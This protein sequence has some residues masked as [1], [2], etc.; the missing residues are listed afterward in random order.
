MKS[1]ATDGSK[2]SAERVRDEV[3]A[4]YAVSGRHPNLP[5]RRLRRTSRKPA[6]RWAGRLCKRR[7]I[8]TE[9]YTGGDLVTAIA[10]GASSRCSRATAG[11][12]R[13]A[14]P[15]RRRVPARGGCRAPRHQARE[16]DVA[17]PVA[18]GRR[19]QR[20]A[21]GLRRRGV[22]ADGRARELVGFVGT[23]FFGAPEC[24]RTVPGTARR[25]TCGPSG[26]RCSPSSPPPPR[27]SSAASGARARSIPSVLRRPRR[28]HS[29]M[30]L[31]ESLL[32]IEPEARPSAA[33][34]SAARPGSSGTRPCSERGAQRARRG[35]RRRPSRCPKTRTAV[36]GGAAS[37][38]WTASGRSGL[39]A[40]RRRGG[41]GGRLRRRGRRHHQRG[42]RRLLRAA[43]F[44]L[45]VCL[46]SAAIDALVAQ[47]RRGRLE[48]LRA[49]KAF[50]AAGRFG[51]RRRQ[52]A[53]AHR[54]ARR[55]RTTTRCPRW[56]S[57]A[58]SG[59]RAP[60]EAAMQL[61]AHLRAQTT[62]AAVAELRARRQARSS[63]TDGPAPASSPE[64]RAGFRTAD[65]RDAAAAEAEAEEM[66]SAEKAD[67]ASVES[68]LGV[69]F[70]RVTTLA[71]LHARRRARVR[72]RGGGQE[73]PSR[74]GR[75]TRNYQNLR[76]R[77][78][79]RL[80]VPACARR[81]VA[82]QAPERGG[83]RC[84]A[85]CSWPCS[86]GR[87]AAPA[88]RPT[89]GATAG[90]GRSCA[91]DA[92]DFPEGKRRGGEESDGRRTAEDSVRGVSSRDIELAPVVPPM[93]RLQSA[94]GG[95]AER[96]HRALAELVAGGDGWRRW[97]RR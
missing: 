29:T 96:E 92:A 69:E 77:A 63:A 72:S 45:S 89:G 94:G 56:C 50:D 83:P 18:E 33:A 53:A 93:A 47:L 19:A 14:A 79:R 22:C 64:W 62:N 26:S 52:D 4:M 2:R 5:V 78:S 32:T 9:A 41:A 95:R 97:R 60:I 12:Y 86:P 87:A 23:K 81:E 90:R 28:A 70:R 82:D 54:S 21:G 10:R 38:I 74:V 51:G 25:A 15:G 17:A 71:D 44:I 6:G 49:E 73:R 55:S 24:F 40:A 16:R 13:R 20:R 76:R 57:S 39:H 58:R 68:A 27:T 91:A 42:T 11:G 35:P 8:V 65:Q 43:A 61:D 1:I 75:L 34:R 85:A 30:R 88:T 66:K 48:R 36:P 31:I 7:H 37:R 67:R 59:R 80:D 84:T 46:D 3:D